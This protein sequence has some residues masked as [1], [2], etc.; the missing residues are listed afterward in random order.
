MTDAR[1]DVASPRL[2]GGRGEP[3]PP[4]RARKPWWHR[5]GLTTSRRRAL[6]SLL[7]GVAI[8]EFVARVLVDGSLFFVPLTDVV[9]AGYD[10]TL[11]GELQHHAW[12]SFQEF[13]YGLL[14]A[15]L[16]GV[17][18]GMAV[19]ISTRVRDYVQPW[20]SGFYSTPLIALAPLFILWLGIGIVSKVAVVFAMAL[21]PI[22]INTTAGIKNTDQDLID[23]A[24]AFGYSRTDIFR[25]VLLPS[26]LS[27]IV[28]GFRLAVGRGIVAVVVAEFFGSRGGLGYLILVSSQSFA[29]DRLL[30]AVLLL[31]FTGVIGIGLV[32]RLERRLAPWREDMTV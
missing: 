30:L 2:A 22:T 4:V 24:R 19:G 32:G 20:I 31:A 25:K 9:R 11:T 27:F 26:A 23:V 10:L 16:V 15:V 29:M 13:F 14:L 1:T 21:F 28:T 17:P 3:S 12:V 7:I 18:L 6:I 5:I 8:W